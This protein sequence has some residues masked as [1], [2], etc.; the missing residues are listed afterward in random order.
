LNVVAVADVVT[1]VK[2]LAAP[3]AAQ[4]LEVPV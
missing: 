1:A 3:S 2:K 4:L